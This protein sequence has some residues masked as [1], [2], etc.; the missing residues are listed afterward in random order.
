M[1]RLASAIATIVCLSTFPN[2]ANG[3]CSFSPLPEG[4]LV[5][6]K[7]TPAQRSDLDARMKAKSID[8]EPLRIAILQSVLPTR[9]NADR[10]GRA[11]IIYSEMLARWSRSVKDF[12]SAAQLVAKD[13][14]DQDLITGLVLPLAALVE[15]SKN[16]GREDLASVAALG[17][18]EI[19]P[20][21]ANRYCEEFSLPRP[22]LNDLALPLPV[23]TPAP[24]MNPNTKL[25]LQ[26]H[27]LLNTMPPLDRGSLENPG[28]GSA[29]LIFGDGSFWKH[30][31][32]A[33]GGNAKADVP[34]R[35]ECHTDCVWKGI[36]TSTPVM[37]VETVRNLPKA[38]ENA[39]NDPEGKRTNGPFLGAMLLDAATEAKAKADKSYEETYNKCMQ[40]CP[41][42]EPEPVKQNNQ[43][44]DP[45]KG[46]ELTPQT[47]NDKNDKKNETD[48][49]NQANSDKKKD[50]KNDGKSSFGGQ[51][52]T[53]VATN[54]GTPGKSVTTPYL[55]PNDPRC[56]TK[57]PSDPDYPKECLGPFADAVGKVGNIIQC[58]GPLGPPGSPQR[59]WCLSLVEKRSESLTPKK[60]PA[61]EAPLNE[62]LPASGSGVRSGLSSIESRGSGAAVVLTPADK[63]SLQDLLQDPTYGKRF[64]AGQRAILK[65]LSQ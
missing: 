60:A 56:V 46:P 63:R 11:E 59:A 52:V 37:L 28:K 31:F 22:A 12:Q 36:F 40:Q 27:A 49:N 9:G 5:V 29:E 54:T 44:I 38:A 57:D 32:S 16:L 65:D 14:S 47:K 53:P 21:L 17:L 23:G 20:E 13:V 15:G 10:Y 45:E 19:N 2:L 48:T 7:L 35:A 55:D 64:S 25:A 18:A 6:S 43:K 58:R 33:K 50:T 34:T 61:T 39:S 62:S 42:P 51:P 26:V 24:N 41:T 3:A 30:Q 4:Q 8:Y 1:K